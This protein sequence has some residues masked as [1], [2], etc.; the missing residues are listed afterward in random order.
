MLLLPLPPPISLSVFHK[1]FALPPCSAHVPI[2]APCRS[3][4][5][6]L[7][8]VVRKLSSYLQLLKKVGGQ[9]DAHLSRQAGSCR[10]QWRDEQL[11]SCGL[12]CILGCSGAICYVL[13]VGLCRLH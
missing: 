8:T 5:S 13:F 12:C 6:D 9:P 7:H 1:T 4:C 10:E 2:L 11:L 3:V